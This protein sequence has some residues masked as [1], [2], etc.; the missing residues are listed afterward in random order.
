MP[1]VTFLLNQKVKSMLDYKLYFLK[2]ADFY[3]PLKNNN[4]S[5]IKM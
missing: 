5:A 2:L 3:E 1:D 4:K